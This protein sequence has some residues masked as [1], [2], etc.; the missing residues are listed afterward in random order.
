MLDN[1]Q[2]FFG[3]DIGSTATKGALINNAGEII[4]TTVEPIGTGTAGSSLVSEKIKDFAKQHG[5]NIVQTLATGYGRFTY[6]EEGS[7]EQKSEISCHAKGIS[8]L[9]PNVRTIIDIGGQDV[10]A[11][12]L[13]D[14]GR[15]AN[16]VMNDKCAAGTGRFIETM[17]KVINV[18]LE[19]FGELS[20]QAKTVASISSTCTVFAESEVVSKLAT[21]V[22]MPDL[23]AGIHASVAKRVIGLVCR[24]GIKPDIALSGG[25]SLNTGIIAA[26]EHE[27]KTHLFVS[28]YSQ[29]AGAIGAALFAKEL[30]EK[31]KG[32][33]L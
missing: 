13:N 27:L 18:P 1:K 17:A 16:F 19:K 4:Y 33:T 24:N 5:L 14:N 26:L 7:G 11:I 15:I 25:V 2:I 23:I 32:A 22:S 9:F 31:G 28:K 21:G 20:A 6:A 29:M 8:F 3:I 10:K 12:R 30:F